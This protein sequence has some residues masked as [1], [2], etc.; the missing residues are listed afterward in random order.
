MG[1]LGATMGD[2]NGELAN[3]ITLVAWGNAWLQGREPEPIDFER[4][5]TTYRFAREVEFVVPGVPPEP[6]GVVTTVA[7]WLACLRA[8]GTRRLGL[9]A[10]S[11]AGALPQRLAAAFAGHDFGHIAGV[12]TVTSAWKP[13]REVVAP[14]ASD[15]KI[16]QLRLTGTPGQGEPPVPS[17]LE[18]ARAHD[19]LDASLAAMGN[20]CEREGVP[21]WGER[22]AAAIALGAE[23]DP[24]IPFHPDLVPPSTEP[25]VRRLLATASAGWVFGGMGSWN[26]VSFP[27]PEQGDVAEWLTAQLYD[28]T[29]AAIVAAANRTGLR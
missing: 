7:E 3:L 28:K 13:T 26:D 8:L 22:F 2:V 6:P 1:P 15:E 21:L 27:E 12:G 17:E 18:L 5:N 4:L 11:Y 10:A 9:E 20:F 14:Q 19:E 16:W 24:V 25:A 29:V 23:D